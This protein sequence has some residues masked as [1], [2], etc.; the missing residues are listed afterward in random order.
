MKDQDKTKKR[1]INELSELRKRN[2]ELETHE[3]ERKRIEEKLR[4]REEQYRS[5]VEKFGGIA[6]RGDA[7][8]KIEFFHGAVNEI[9]GYVEDDFVEDKV[10]WT[11]MIHKDD[12]PWTLDDVKRVIF[13]KLSSSEREYRIISKDKKVK[14]VVERV[15]TIFDSSGQIMGSQGTIYDITERKQAEK[16][17]KESEKLFSDFFNQGNIGAVISSLK[18]GFIRTNQKFLDLLGYTEKELKKKTWAEMTHPE[19]LAADVK[20]H[21]KLLAGKINNYELDKRFFRKDGSTLY[22]HITVTCNRNS[23]GSPK[24]MLATLQDTTEKKKAEDALR[25]S[26]E[27]LRNLAAHL[28]SVREDERKSVAREIHDDV[29]QN[30]AA[31]KMD[32]Y[33][34]EKKLPSDQKPLIDRM[35]A[36]M[37][38]T[39]KS[40]QIV[41]KI[42]EELRPSILDVGG[43]VEATKSYKKEFEGK[44][45]VRCELYIEPES[46]D[47]SEERTL[48]FFRILQES[49]TNVKLH[50]GATKVNVSIKE[51]NGKLEL[52][53]KDNGV[54][55]S[56]EHLTKSK[57]YGLM[58]IKERVDFLEGEVKIKG[59][60]GK[61]TTVTIRI[62]LKTVNK[63]KSR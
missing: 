48:A 54:G 31:L 35:K 9:T 60:P 6:F 29:G 11:D 24:H 4:E 2:A 63:D 12:L 45:G 55:I 41:R 52:K 30:L 61:G 58:G 34:I 39:D 50:A 36:M 17:L 51:K 27:D 46:I 22:S 10:K 42:H 32:M 56:E 47:L 40:V 1:L 8:F 18:K 26:Q 37:E 15:N 28:Q 25:K 59:I 53:V 43:I 44:T 5:F 19:D 49:M 23:D 57:S 3:T 33:M 38:L 16:A 20:L 13:E 21:N 7:N 14:W 62:P